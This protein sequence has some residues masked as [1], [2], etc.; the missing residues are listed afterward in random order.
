MLIVVVE[1]DEFCSSSL[2][3][4]VV[5]VAANIDIGKSGAGPFLLLLDPALD[6]DLAHSLSIRDQCGITLPQQE[7]PLTGVV[8]TGGTNLHIP[9]AGALANPARGRATPLPTPWASV[10]RIA[11]A[12]EIAPE[13][14]E[15]REL[16]RE[17]LVSL[18][19]HRLTQHAGLTGDSPPLGTERAVEA[20]VGHESESIFLCHPSLLSR[21]PL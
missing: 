17:M 13:R 4:D 20:T 14:L 11:E 1:D 15:V 8:L 19:A 7:H 18:A 12:R 2:L 10:L 3:W 16:P 5:R 21:Y 6:P 9:V